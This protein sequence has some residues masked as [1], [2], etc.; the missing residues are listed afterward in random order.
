MTTLLFCFL[1]TPILCLPHSFMRSQANGNFHCREAHQAPT[2]AWRTLIELDMTSGKTLDKAYDQNQYA[3]K[4]INIL[5]RMGDMHALWMGGLCYGLGLGLGLL[6][7][8]V[9][10]RVSLMGYGYGSL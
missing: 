1:L 4:N 8:R 9:R 2:E 7:V 10:V 5:V 6:R 3:R